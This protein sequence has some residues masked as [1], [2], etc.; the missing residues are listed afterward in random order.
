MTRETKE[1]ECSNKCGVSTTVNL[2]KKH[3]NNGKRFI[4]GF[5]AA[6]GLKETGDNVKKLQEKLNTEV[7]TLTKLFQEAQVSLTKLNDN[8]KNGAAVIAP[9]VTQPDRRRN[10]VALGISET[11]NKD[12]K[13]RAEEEMQQIG[14]ILEEVG[15]NDS[16]ETLISEHRRLG[17]YQGENKK[18]P[19]L[20]VCNNEWD[21]RRIM[22]AFAAQ[23]QE[24]NFRLRNDVPMTEE[25]KTALAEARTKNDAEKE[26]AQNEGREVKISFSARDDGTVVEYHEMNGRWVKAETVAAEDESD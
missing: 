3:Y 16:P 20:I 25:R 12:F 26:A 15:I 1:I 17:R 19:L 4:C 7:A 5:C 23:R 22:N 6:D 14:S 10:I 9:T 18:R 13:E 8:F 11:E 24:V 2:P 21:K